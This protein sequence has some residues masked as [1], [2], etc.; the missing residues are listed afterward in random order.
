MI[1][2][3]GTTNPPNPPCTSLGIPLEQPL[4]PPILPASPR[5]LSK[6]E[7]SQR[8]AFGSIILHTVQQQLARMPR[9]RRYTRRCREMTTLVELSEK[10]VA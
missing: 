1:S 4:H 6:T 10:S 8:L 3:A 5:K 9:T 2:A 7:L